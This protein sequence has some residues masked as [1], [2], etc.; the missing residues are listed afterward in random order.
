VGETAIV[1]LI[2][3]LAGY[4]ILIGLGMP[5]LAGDHLR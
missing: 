1:T 4:K 5:R 3:A 2:E